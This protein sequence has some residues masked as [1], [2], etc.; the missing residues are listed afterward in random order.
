MKKKI[1]Y[2]IIFI[3]IN[4]T[5][6]S[7]SKKIVPTSLNNSLQIPNS[8]KEIMKSLNSSV[9]KIVN[10]GRNSKRGNSVIERIKELGLNKYTSTE[11]IDWLSSQKNILITIKGETDKIIYIVSHYDKVDTN[12]LVL[13]SVLLN[14]VLDPLISWSYLSHGAIDNA[15]GVAL[16]L[17]LAKHIL[18]NDF[19]HNYKILLVGSEESGLRGSRSHVARLSDST[20]NKIFYVINTDVIG[21][22]G[23]KNCVTTNVSNSRLS[24]ISLEIAKELKIE[25]DKGSMPFLA[26]SDYASFKK[27]DFFTDFGRSLSFNLIGALLPQR[28]YFTS[29]KETEV[30]NFSSCELLDIGDYIGGSLLIPIGSIHGFRDNIKMVDEQKLFEQFTLTSSFIKKMETIDKL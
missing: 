28:S 15:T 24:S 9:E 27:T 18:K 8:Q 30:I 2:Y 7:C 4:L 20:Y 17:Q 16:S 13:P 11:K 12:P 14:G 10:A 29:K 1:P 26:C 22:K 6:T 21:V 3:L 5:Y 23:K 19:K 25:L